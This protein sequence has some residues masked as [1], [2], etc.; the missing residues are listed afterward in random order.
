[1]RYAVPVLAG[2]MTL[3]LPAALQAQ[4]APAPFQDH[5]A[6]VNGVRLHYERERS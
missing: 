5:Y 2:F 4:S 6:E 3:A 1:M